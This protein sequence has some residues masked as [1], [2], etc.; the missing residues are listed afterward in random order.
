MQSS[1][2]IPV[3]EYV[4]MSTEDQKYSISNQQDAI[5]EYALRHGFCVCR[6]Y[7]D[8]GRSGVLIRHRRGLNQLLQDVLGGKAGYKA[9]LVYD[10]SR[11]GRFQDL[12]EAAHYEFLCKSA[13]IPVHYCAETFAN[14][15]SMSS[16]IMKALKRAMAGEYSR[17]LGNKVLAGQKRLAELGFKMGGCA[18]YGLR[19]MLVTGDRKPKQLLADGERKS[20]TT[21]R[22]VYVLGP[23]SEVEQVREIFRLFIDE[24][25]SLKA[26]A[27]ELNLRRVPYSR[28]NQWTNYDVQR[29]LSDPKYTGCSV[30]N[31][32]SMRL[33]TRPVWTPKA[34]WIVTQNAHEG[35]VDQKTFE[36]A[37]KL[38]AD[39][40]IHKSNDRI[41]DDLKRL[42]ALKGQLTTRIIKECP[43]M[44]GVATFRVRF[45]GLRP[46]FRMIGYPE[47]PLRGTPPLTRPKRLELMST[48]EQLFPDEVS[49]VDGGRCRDRLKL[50]NGLMVS[51]LIA[52]C[53]RGQS[54]RVDISKRTCRSVTLV[55]WLNETNR[56]FQKFYIF[57]RLNLRKRSTSRGKIND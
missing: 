53:I 57:P 43:D 9:V 51:V 19:R 39:F 30:F 33:G 26:I 22:V 35:I 42:W 38:L 10:V 40:T 14:D 20:I 44:P 41:L 52:R 45:G 27:R 17:E 6:T 55:G 3:A 11:W 46:A 18:A 7:G 47:N 25:M 32:R 1:S 34:E 2:S 49:I 37:Q 16:L 31:R 21:D 5:R 12:D 29:L 23:P 15:G 56:E 24:R 13:G 36:V 4:R 50:R 48:I 54:W 28:N 8:P